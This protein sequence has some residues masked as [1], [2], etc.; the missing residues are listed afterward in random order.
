LVP[1]IPSPGV[2]LLVCNVTKLISI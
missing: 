2:K 1:D